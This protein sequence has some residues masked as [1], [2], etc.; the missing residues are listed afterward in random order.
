[1]TEPTNEQQQQEQAIVLQSLKYGLEQ[2]QARHNLRVNLKNRGLSVEDISVILNK[3]AIELQFEEVSL[4][5]LTSVVSQMYAGDEDS[6]TEE[7]SEEEQ[8]D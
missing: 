8:K 3:P 1:M 6:E 7:G 4:S 5:I 2:L